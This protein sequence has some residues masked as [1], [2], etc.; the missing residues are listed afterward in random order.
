MAAPLLLGLLT[1]GG[2]V[3]L[4][5]LPTVERISELD[6]R[7]Q[8]LRALQAQ[9]PGMLQR[10][11]VAQNKL[12]QAQVKQAVLLDLIAGRDRIQTFLALLDQRA[13][14]T[15]VE[16]QRFEP[17]QAELSLK[18]AQSRPRGSSKQ[19]SSD[20]VDPLQD[21]GYRRTA[22]ALNVVGSYAQLQS[23]LQEMEKLEV[24]VE[25]SDLKLEAASDSGEEKKASTNQQKIELS[26]RF[27][28]YDRSPAKE[29]SSLSSA[30]SA[31]EAPS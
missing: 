15:G 20:P 6:A 4:Q 9:V 3:L 10:L 29:P 13:R 11:D 1:A 23:F 16:I 21:L 17:L 8:E 22:V 18:K 31:E 14:S 26:L 2:L 28:F 19:N 24:V 12:E 30:E 27:S 25:A 5:L 7:L